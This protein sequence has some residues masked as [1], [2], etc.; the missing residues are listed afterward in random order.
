MGKTEE[1][2]SDLKET[3]QRAIIETGSSHSRILPFA[4]APRQL[5]RKLPAITN[6]A[7]TSSIVAK[8]VGVPGGVG[9][10]GWGEGVARNDEV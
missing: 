6:T 5:D 8:F 4:P 9:E 7:T 3:E 2:S 10:G 1:E